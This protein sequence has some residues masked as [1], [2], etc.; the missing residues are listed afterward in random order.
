MA[1]VIADD[2]RDLVDLMAETLSIR[3][4]GV[5][6]KAYN[7][8]D[9]AELCFATKP[10]VLLLDITMPNYDGVY[11]LKEIQKRKIQIKIIILTGDQNPKLIGEIIRFNPLAILPSP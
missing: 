8:K 10:E 6:G 2:D 11:A 4:V 1:V 9:A 5:L 7:G 3:G